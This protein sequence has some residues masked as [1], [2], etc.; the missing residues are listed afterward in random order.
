[1]KR[2]LVPTIAA[3]LSLAT[4]APAFAAGAGGGGNWAFVQPINNFAGALEAITAALVVIALIV[5]VA[6]HMIHREDW[7]GMVRNIIFVVI[8]GAVIV[9]AAN[10]M[11]NA[12]VTGA[13]L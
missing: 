4:R 7:G 5:I 1:M 12:G 10:F 8:G 2:A 6:Q 3:I 13:H 11:Q 9:T